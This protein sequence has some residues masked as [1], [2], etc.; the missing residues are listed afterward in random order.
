MATI[1]FVIVELGVMQRRRFHSKSSLSEEE[2]GTWGA[3][4]SVTGSPASAMPSVGH[5]SP[6]EMIKRLHDTFKRIDAVVSLYATRGVCKI[7]T[8]RQDLHALQRPPL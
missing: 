8:V 4:G 5:I 3:R 1:G 2:L 7:E 6:T